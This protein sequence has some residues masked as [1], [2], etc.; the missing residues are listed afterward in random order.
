MDG[1]SLANELEF[2]YV[3]CVIWLMMDPTNGPSQNPPSGQS[4]F[5]GMDGMALLAL[6]AVKVKVETEP[7]ACNMHSSTAKRY[8]PRLDA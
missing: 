8:I 1:R 6:L 5:W 2:Q 4:F 7:L 3:V